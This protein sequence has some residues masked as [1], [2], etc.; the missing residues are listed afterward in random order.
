M[1]A[2]VTGGGGQLAKA[3]RRTAAEEYELSMHSIETLD[4]T[5]SDQVEEIVNLFRPDVIIN[6][7]AYTDVDGAE[8][9][10]KVAAVVNGNGPGIL[11]DAAERH[12]SSLIHVSTDFVFDGSSS[13]PLKTDDPT[14]PVSTYG[15][16]KL[17]GESAIIDSALQRWTIVR[18]A[19]LYDETSPNFLSAMIRMME[20]NDEIRVVSDQTGTPTRSKSLAIALWCIAEGGVVGMHH[21]TDAGSTT[22]HGFATAI[23]EIGFEY[24]LFTSRTKVEPISTEEYPTPAR[25]PS[26]SV[27][28]KTN[29]WSALDGTRAMPAVHWRDNLEN[30]IREKIR[31]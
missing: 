25:R 23:E 5:D 17:D 2:L 19:W 29:T 15:R 9:D 21:W 18:T 28:D 7:A 13:G 10:R 16:T 1:K 31:V 11:A 14:N 24:G 8:T 30:T 20:A 22:W 26:Y 27:L 6:T 4:I 12:G 3:L